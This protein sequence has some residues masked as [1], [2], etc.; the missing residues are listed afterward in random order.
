VPHER[1]RTIPGPVEVLGGCKDADMDL[2]QRGP[3][4]ERLPENPDLSG[5]QVAA[6]VPPEPAADGVD[7][8]VPAPAHTPAAPPTPT[9][10]PTPA[11]PAAAPA[12]A[13]RLNR[14][15]D[16]RQE[17]RHGLHRRVESHA[18]VPRPPGP[19]VAHPERH[20][21]AGVGLLVERVTEIPEP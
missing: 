7:C 20:A 15:S 8:L 1:R 12:A 2:R 13:G 9:P 14:R 3:L 6:E 16:R 10:V 11:A 5:V 18:L 17:R 19:P 21:P 4:G